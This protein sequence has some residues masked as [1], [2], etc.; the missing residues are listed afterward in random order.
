MRAA[1]WHGYKDLRIEEVPVPVPGPGKVLIKVDWAGI[2]G[3]DRHE[4]EG[5]NFIP[6]KKPHRL[7]GPFAVEAR[8]TVLFD[9]CDQ[10]MVDIVTG[11]DQILCGHGF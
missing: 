11:V 1:V 4:Y 2:C 3:T 5:P 10:L 7:T 6:V 9:I 8:I